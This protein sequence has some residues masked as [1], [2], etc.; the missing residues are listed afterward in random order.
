[1]KAGG[2]GGERKLGEGWWGG[3]G[4][5]SLDVTY[6]R[7]ERIHFVG[8]IFRLDFVSSGKPSPKL[9]WP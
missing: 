1:M 2:E 9:M 4:N 8:S 5:C 3:R 6:E 7:K